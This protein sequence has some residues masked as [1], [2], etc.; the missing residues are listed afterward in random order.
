LTTKVDI[1]WVMAFYTF[2]HKERTREVIV[3]N[4]SG[5]DTCEVV[6]KR[7]YS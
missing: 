1:A 2:L 3:R 4:L 7:Y 6:G 5:F